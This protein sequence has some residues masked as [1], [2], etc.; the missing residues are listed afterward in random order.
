MAEKGSN[1]KGIIAIIVIIILAAVVLY[2]VLGGEREIVPVPETTISETIIEVE[3]PADAMPEATENADENANEAM[4][5]D[6][7]MGDGEASQPSDE[8]STIDASQ[9]EPAPA[10]DDTNASADSN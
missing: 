6:N 2:F 8:Q 7:A 4:S 1:A 9:Q 5:N 10:A 3:P